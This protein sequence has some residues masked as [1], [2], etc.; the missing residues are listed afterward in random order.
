MTK[1]VF[2]IH[3]LL[4]CFICNSQNKEKIKGNR[5]VTNELS[6][7]LPFEKLVFGDNFKVTLVQGCDPSVEVVAD[8]NLHDV[9]TFNVLEGNLKF[10][11]THKITSSKMLDLRVVYTEELK[12]IELLGNAEVNAPTTLKL[13]SLKL[14]SNDFTKAN[15]NIIAKDFKYISKGKSK[16]DLGITSNTIQLNLK[17]NAKLNASVTASAIET[18]LKEHASISI[19]GGSS[20]LHAKL[21]E[22]SKL[23]AE[24]LLLDDITLVTKDKCDVVVNASKTLV[25]EASGD[26]ETIIYGKPEIN[27]IKFENNA[28][29]RKKENV[30]EKNEAENSRPN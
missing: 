7:I 4:V 30:K 23:N 26:T 28:I 3:L 20:K 11:T 2:L 25:I 22:T 8:S 19:E 14:V 12:T 5:L 15:F 24:N 21:S 27:L 1:Q 10:Q 13:D 16:A 18:D 6:E 17:E 9:I 29:L